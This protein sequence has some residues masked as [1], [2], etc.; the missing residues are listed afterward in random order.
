[1]AKKPTDAFSD[2]LEK[3]KDGT[4]GHIHV[5]IAYRAWIRERKDLP[6]GVRDLLAGNHE[7]NAGVLFT[8]FKLISQIIGTT[9][10]AYRRGYQAGQEETTNAKARKAVRA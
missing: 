9:E 1:M 3:L 5:Q 6:A 8:A 2:L 10:L 7:S 4:L